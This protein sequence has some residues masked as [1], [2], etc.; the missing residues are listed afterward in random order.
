MRQ[1][2]LTSL[3]ASSLLFGATSKLDDTT[4]LVW[5]DNDGMTKE[6]KSYDQ[7]LEYCKNLTLDG[8]DDWRVPTIKEFYTIV[9]LRFDRPALKRGFEMRIDDKFWTANLFAGNSK[10]EAWRINMSY[11]E[12]E[13][14]SKSR[15][16]FVRCVRGT[17]Q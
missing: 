2:L 9:D 14:Y 7:A 12:A 8:F 13:A 11:G 5:Q 16:Y 6:Q 17:R 10:K 3:L 15:S 1:I 4:G